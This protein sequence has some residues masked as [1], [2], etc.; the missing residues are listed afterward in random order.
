MVTPVVILIKAD[1]MDKNYNDEYLKL[2]KEN[3]IESQQISPINFLHFNV[4]ILENEFKNNYENYWALV[5]T[6]PRAALIIN[7]I[8]KNKLND[9][10]LN[11]WNLK[12]IFAVIY[13]KNN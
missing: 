6:S 9:S 11:I 1:M 5:V 10:L 13:C 3:D 2:F 7:N 12:Y 4:N 8:F